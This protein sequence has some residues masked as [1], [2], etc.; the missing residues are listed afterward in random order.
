[1][2]F[3]Q[4]IFIIVISGLIITGCLEGQSKN[5]I[6]KQ[7]DNM[8]ENKN[9][10][11]ATFGEGCFWCSEAIFERVNGVYSVVSG[12]AG[13]TT[14]DPNYEEVCTGMTGHAEVVQIKF[15]P[16]IVSYEDLLKIF[17]KT[18]DPTTLNRQGAD[19]GTQYRSVI[20]YHNE[21]QKKK[22]EYYKD[23]LRQ[24]KSLG[25]TDCNADSSFY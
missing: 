21:D 25:Q 12:Y 19:I 8:M 11:T 18:H 17:W 5:Q 3:I 10:S 1:M 9:L 7:K 13:G 15:D 24:I 22:A 6:K 16:N 23:Q 4:Y 20:F 2:K 14:K